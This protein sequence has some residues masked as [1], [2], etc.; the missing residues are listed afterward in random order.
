MRT[1]GVV[2]TQLTLLELLRLARED[3]YSGTYTRAPADCGS[4]AK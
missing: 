4:R 1:I 3:W 2:E